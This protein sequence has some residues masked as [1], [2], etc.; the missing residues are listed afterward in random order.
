[1]AEHGSLE[2]EVDGDS[3]WV[4]GEWTR[5]FGFGPG[6]GGDEWWDKLMDR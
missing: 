5:G 3:G 1:M 4:L 6:G 2:G